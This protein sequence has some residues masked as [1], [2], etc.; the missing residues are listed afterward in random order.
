MSAFKTFIETA[1]IVL[2]ALVALLELNRA[3]LRTC[4]GWSTQP[5]KN[6]QTVPKTTNNA[7]FFI[8]TYCY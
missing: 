7:L 2:K 6:K 8:Q 5:D 4:F 3:F 1:I